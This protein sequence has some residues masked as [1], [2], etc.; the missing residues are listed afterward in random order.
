M[1]IDEVEV[2]VGIVLAGLL[3]LVCMVIFIRIIQSPEEKRSGLMIL[4]GLTMLAGVLLVGDA[5]I[6]SLIVTSIVAMGCLYALHG[7][8]TTESPKTFVVGILAASMITSLLLSQASRSFDLGLL[9]WFE[10][11]VHDRSAAEEFVSAAETLQ[12]K[13]E[14]ALASVAEAQEALEDA[15]ARIDAMDGENEAI[16]TAVAELTRRHNDLIARV[17][18]F[19]EGQD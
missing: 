17:D 5:P 8:A 9:H 15:T 7:A 1:T 2:Y 18:M 6:V 13:A 4:L 19:E 10:V 14:A 3:S 12:T 16:A 11:S